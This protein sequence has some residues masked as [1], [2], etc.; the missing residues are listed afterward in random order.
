MK[1]ML[2]MILL[3]C[4]CVFT[5]AEAEF[6]CVCG[7]AQCTC[8]MQLGDE[9]M[10][11]EAAAQLL[12]QQG[13]MQ[14]SA[15][16]TVFSAQMEAA[17]RAFQREHHLPESGM[18]DDATLT[19]LIWGMSPDALDEEQPLLCG[20]PV[21]IPTDGGIRHHKRDSCCKMLDPR[22]V[23]QRNALAMDM[24]ECGRCKPNGFNT[25]LP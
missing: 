13:Y 6:G 16:E 24:L 20:N 23:S 25:E 17:V 18:L 19:W 4:I 21:W 22:L 15:P 5:A 11:V 8:F 2:V 12:V 9:G 7:D 3:L 14:Q 10:G 1:R